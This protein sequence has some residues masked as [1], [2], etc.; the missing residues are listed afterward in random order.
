MKTCHIGILSTGRADYGLLTPLLDE[1]SKQEYGNVSLL[2]T[3]SHLSSAHG[4][5]VEWIEAEGRP[6][7]FRAPMAPANDTPHGTNLAIADGISR[8]SAHFCVSSY[9]L[10]IVLG[11][12]FELMACCI[13]AFF[14]RI[15][16]AHLHGGETTLGALDDSIRHCAS[17]MASL[18]FPALPQYAERLQQMGESE[19]RIHMV[20]ALGI[21][22]IQRIPACSRKEWDSSLGLNWGEDPFILLTYH[23]ATMESPERNHAEFHS[24]LEVLEASSFRILATLPNADM[25]SR[26]LGNALQEFAKLHQERVEVRTSLGHGGYVNAMRHA[27][28]MI[29]NSSSG[30][31]EAASV[32]LPVVN[33][34][35]RQEGRIHAANVIDCAG[36]K[37][38]I[39]R[40]LQEAISP[41][42]R[43]RIAGIANPYGDGHAAERIV[44][45]L[46]S[47][48][49][50]NQEA[51]LKKGSGA[52]HA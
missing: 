7:S 9:D 39:Q 6:I 4:L 28:C 1:F 18:H 49:L 31:L 25:G 51:L 52:I 43:A 22:A 15:P 34:G 8:F 38:A 46:A 29:G 5:T 50:A 36:T 48:D 26:D 40:A 3:G 44:A 2:I 37:D 23:P 17:H 35:S 42:F 13:A 30:I 16:I 10:L 14:H 20:G 24:L 47:M 12:R 27:R 19:D 41:E 11:D 45:V 32:P 33:V 21:D